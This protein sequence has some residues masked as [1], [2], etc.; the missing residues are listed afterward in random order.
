MKYFFEDFRCENLKTVITKFNVI[1]N[2]PGFRTRCV[3]RPFE[4]RVLPIEDNKRLRIKKTRSKGKTT[5]KTE[6]SRKYDIEKD[7]HKMWVTKLELL[8]ECK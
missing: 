1:K 8:N 7:P 4:S 6:V 2:Q 3:C 5:K